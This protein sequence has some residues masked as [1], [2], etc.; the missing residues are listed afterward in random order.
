MRTLL[1]IANRLLI[2]F[3]LFPCDGHNQGSRVDRNHSVI[4]LQGTGSHWHVECERQQQG[5]DEQEA[6]VLEIS[7]L[8]I[9][10][11]RSDCRMQTN[12]S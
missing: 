11:K 4:A 9:R 1:H 5:Y 7:L 12:S 3:V 8:I 10:S 2:S 6:H